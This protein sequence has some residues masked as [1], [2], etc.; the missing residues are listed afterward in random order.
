MLGNLIIISVEQRFVPFQVKFLGNVCE[1][2]MAKK[3]QEGKKKKERKKE[4]EVF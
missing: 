4:R 1:G 3:K 2:N